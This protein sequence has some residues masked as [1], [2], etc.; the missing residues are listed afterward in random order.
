VVNSSLPA[1]FWSKVEKTETCWLWTGAR[2][3]TGYGSYWHDARVQTSHRVAYETFVGP[4]HAGLQLD[5]LCR[6][7]NCVNPD[8]L[9][10]VTPQENV[11]RGEAG[12]VN[13][14]RQRNRTTC[15]NGHQRD[16]IYE[17]R[18]I[19]FCRACRRDVDSRRGATAWPA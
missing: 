14:A 9:E 4:V 2:N 16:D 6:I 15:L 10:P 1:R 11:R 3:S 12:A 5:H 19:R 17:W 18:G 8:H 13:G 7:R